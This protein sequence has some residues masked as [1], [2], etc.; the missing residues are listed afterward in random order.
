MVYELQV[1][2]GFDLYGHVVVRS[3]VNAFLIERSNVN[4]S[5]R[6]HGTRKAFH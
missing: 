5:V 1:G 4:E 6:M 3:P 2:T